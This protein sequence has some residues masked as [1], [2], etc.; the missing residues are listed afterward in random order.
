MDSLEVDENVEVDDCKDQINRL[1]YDV[2]C[3]PKYR[4]DLVVIKDQQDQFKQFLLES[5][6]L[7]RALNLSAKNKFIFEKD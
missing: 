3:L 5:D 7:S 1:S 4:A 6:K 2:E